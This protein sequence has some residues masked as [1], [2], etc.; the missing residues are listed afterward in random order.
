MMIMNWKGC[1]RKRRYHY[2]RHYPEIRMGRLWE[3]TERTCHESRSQGL[4]YRTQRNMELYIWG[5]KSKRKA[6]EILVK[7]FCWWN[8]LTQW[9]VYREKWQ[10]HAVVLVLNHGELWIQ[11]GNTTFR[12]LDMF[13]SSGKGGGGDTFSVGSLRKSEPQSLDETL[14]FIV[15]RISDDGQSPKTQ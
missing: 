1:G 12:K 13:P 2:L 14:C 8:A 10:F 3:T 5:I 6:K 15:S 4:P 9:N 7:G 11:F